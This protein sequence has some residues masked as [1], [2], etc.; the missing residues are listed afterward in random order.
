MIDIHSHILPGIDDG[1]ETMDETLEMAWAYERAGFEA[2]IA[3]PHHIPGTSWHV[4]PETI[5]RLVSH[6]NDTLVHEGIRLH[7]KPGMEIGLAPEVPRLLS[8]KG[9]LTLADSC[10]LLLESPFQRLPLNWEQTIFDLAAHGYRIVWAHPERCGQLQEEPELLNRILQLGGF[11]QVNWGSILE[12]N[13]S[14][15]CAFAKQMIGQGRVHCMATDSHD[16]LSRRPDNA[17]AGMRALEDMAGLET[18]DMLAR[19][20]PGRILRSETLNNVAPAPGASR[21]RSNG[22]RRFFQWKRR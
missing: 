18:V 21:E 5:R 3:T 20:T 7:L 16:A 9:L 1:P 8:E 17:V 22:T 14:D 10:Y 6:V 15:V 13:G 2:V 19:E 4:H 12:Y 11:L